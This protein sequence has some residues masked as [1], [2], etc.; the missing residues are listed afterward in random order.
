[1]KKRKPFKKRINGNEIVLK[2]HEFTPKYAKNVYSVVKN[3][4]EHLLPWLQWVHDTNKVR[5]IMSW[6]KEMKADWK[7]REGASYGI[8]VGTKFIGQISVFGLDY[9]K[10]CGEIGYWIDKD[11][12]NKGYITEAIKLLEKEFFVDRGINKIS[13]KMDADNLAS[14]RIAHKLNYKLEGI[15]RQ[16]GFFR[17]GGGEYRDEKIYSKL[18][19]EYKYYSEK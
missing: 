16:T 18:Y 4:R 8:F 9:V 6:L 7:S 19:Y 11:F 2:R 14:E 5:D 3:S 12:A 1:M 17:E 13:L 10:D 15:S